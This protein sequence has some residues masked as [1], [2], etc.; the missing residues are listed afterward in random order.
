MVPAHLPMHLECEM[1]RTSFPLTHGIPDMLSPM[2]LHTHEKSG[3]WQHMLERHES[4]WRY[5]RGHTRAGGEAKAWR[6]SADMMSKYF[7]LAEING[8]DGRVLD[9]GC[10]EGLRSRHFGNKEY[11]GVDPLTLKREYTFPFLR[12]IGESLPFADDLFDVVISVESLDHVINPEA[13][14]KEACRVLRFG[15]GLFVFVGLTRCQLTGEMIQARDATYDTT[16]ADVHLHEFKPEDFERVL[17][18]HFNKMVIDLE[19]GYLAIWC[20]DLH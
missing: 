12:G 5:E 15:G 18:E 2:K 7:Q 9:I 10:G 20:W 14:L 3:A 13:C 6:P 17:K 8:G 16:E 19:E 4:W 11:Y 1:C